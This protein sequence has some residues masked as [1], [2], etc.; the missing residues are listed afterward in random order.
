MV[1]G[2]QKQKRARPN[3]PVLCI[4]IANVPLIKAIFTVKENHRAK[5]R[6]SSRDC[7]KAWVQGAMIIGGYWCNKQPQVWIQGENQ[8][9]GA[10]YHWRDVQRKI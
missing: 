9:N 3:R 6:V 1:A 8:N 10:T 7:T 5:S 4:M 2:L